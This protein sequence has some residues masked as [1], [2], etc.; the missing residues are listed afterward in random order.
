MVQ[1][2]LVMIIHKKYTEN[3]TMNIKSQFC[4]DY[5]I[6]FLF[7]NPTQWNLNAIHRRQ[8]VIIGVLCTR[9][10]LV[11]CFADIIDENMKIA[12]QKEL[13]VM[14]PGLTIQVFKNTQ[15]QQ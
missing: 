4:E 14:A 8:H 11:C 13:N 12:L 3:I 10:A 6:P 9:M 2:S 7:L 1:L 15:L 5:Y